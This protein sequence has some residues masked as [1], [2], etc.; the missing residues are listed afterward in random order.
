MTRPTRREVRRRQHVLPRALLLGFS[1]Q[2]NIKC[3]WRGG[4]ERVVSATNAAVIKDYYS[5]RSRHGWDDV[6]EV[7]LGEKEQPFNAI[8]ER[9]RSGKDPLPRDAGPLSEFV[10]AALVRS[11]TIRAFMEQIDSAT[12]GW[13]A[14]QF[15]HAE[16]LLDL[17]GHSQ[18]ELQRLAGIASQALQQRQSVVDVRQSRLRTLV[19]EH[20]ELRNPDRLRVAGR[21][22]RGRPGPRR[23]G[24]CC[25]P[26]GPRRLAGRTSQGRTRLPAARPKYRV[27]GLRPGRTPDR[28]TRSEA[29][30]STC[31]RLVVG[32]GRKCSISSPCGSISRGSFQ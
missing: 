3:R 21:G 11:P 7:W 2:G 24:C 10:A 23:C 16:G 13:V 29:F 17:R 8:L 18:A 26:A 4:R 5:F 28:S 20:Q 19:R 12:G 22:E 6:L 25:A 9:L 30:G 31:E 27:G 1:E 15:L 14:L 32:P